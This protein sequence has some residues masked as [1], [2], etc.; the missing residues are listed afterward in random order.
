MPPPIQTQ[1]GSRAAII[2][3]AVIASILFVVATVL[4]IFAT[5]ARTKAE[6]QL[7]DVRRQ[8]Q[9]V[10]SEPALTGDV[11]TSLAAARG[12]LGL[13][14]TTTLLDVAVTQRDALART[15]AAGSTAATAKTAAD[16]ALAN[17][18]ATTKTKS[19]TLV[20]AVDS[21]NNAAKDR[22]TQIDKL[23]AAN[24]ALGK[25]VADIGANAAKQAGA[26]K[27]DIDAV[28]AQLAEATT[29]LE[30]Y[31]GQ[32][33]ASVGEMTTATEEQ[34]KLAQD[35]IAKLTAD[36]AEANTKAKR[37]EDQTKALNSKLVALRQPVDQIARQPDARVMRTGGD[38]VLYIDLGTGDGIAAGMSFEIYDR[39]Q[40]IPKIGD[41]NNDENLPKG[42][43]SVEVIKVSPG[44]SECRIVRQTAGETV[45]EGDAVVNIVFDKN[46]KYNFVVYGAFDLHRSGQSNPADTDVIKRLVTQWGGKIVPKIDA[47][48][49][50]LVIGKVPEV[51]NYTAE[52]LEDPTKKF[53]QEQKQKEVVEYDELLGQAIQLNIPVL[54]QNRFLYFT[55]YYEQAAR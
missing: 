34:T 20:A 25:Q 3:Y 6:Q 2:T 14:N 22:Q 23:T 44:S 9:N 13:P 35:T 12:D 16:K 26:Y 28:K 10:V 41:S 46:M 47:N 49:D 33:D 45:V 24:K 30:A 4:A 37:A 38:G 31:R 17:A 19:N 52:E 1:S 48:T 11:T 51:P 7:S 21:L 40:G 55:G 32:K 15:I 39:I 42:K 18:L 36:V 29:A 27:S 53:A 50:F 54:N 5:V 43:A 8:F